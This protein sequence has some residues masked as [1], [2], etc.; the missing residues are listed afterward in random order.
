MNWEMVAAVGQLAA[1]FIGIPSLIYLAV[2]I[3]EQ[4]KERRQ[5]AV[6]ALTAQWGDLTKALHASS[7]FS[8]L[9]LRGV[10]SFSDL[11]AVSKLR[12]SAFHNRFFHNFEGMYFA[13]CDGI[14]TPPLWGEV[15][16]TMS[17]FLACPGVRQWWA[18]R[19][20]WYTEE[21]ARLVDGIIARGD[22]PTIY[23]TYHLENMPSS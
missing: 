4:T 14:L 18:T 2:Q 12:F 10:Q 11:D 19:K 23:A 15:E 22:E 3:R 5:T 17:N 13:F 20:D 21:F 16:R 8:A 1:V 7:K 9:Y 6:N